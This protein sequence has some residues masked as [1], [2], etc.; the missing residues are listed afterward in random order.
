MITSRNGKGYVFP[1][2]GWEVDESV[3]VAAQRETVE[4]AGVRGEL[5][6]PML[7]TFAFRSGKA[8]RQNA[9]ALKG[10]CIAYMFAMRVSEE[11][12]VWPE[13]QQR[14][15]V[16]VG[17]YIHSFPELLFIVIVALFSPFSKLYTIE[18]LFIYL[19]TSNLWYFFPVYS[20]QLKRPTPVLAMIG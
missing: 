1:K 6:L 18:C 16:W 8:E 20:A 17:C 9:S 2:G 3:E 15:R 10:R 12:N 19:N 13:A 7:G 5:E 11:L 14:H 4:E